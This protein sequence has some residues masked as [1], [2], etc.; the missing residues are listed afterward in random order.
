MARLHSAWL[1]IW[2]FVV[3]DDWQLAVGVIVALG[4]TAIVAG[5]GATAWWIIP[6]VIGLLLFT[7]VWRA[8]RPR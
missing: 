1:A 2:D 7:S 8:A 3:G 6:V 5:T 4:V